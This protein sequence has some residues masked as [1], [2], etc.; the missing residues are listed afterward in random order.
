MMDRSKKPIISHILNFLDYC[1]VEKGLSYNTQKNY[2]RYLKKFTFW[3]KRSKKEKLL[4]HQLTGNDVW[5]YRLF[6]S[7]FKTQ[8]DCTRCDRCMVY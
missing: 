4:P 3:L 8:N 6:L 7:R 2:D 1:E 5:N